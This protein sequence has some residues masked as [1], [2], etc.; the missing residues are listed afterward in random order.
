MTACPLHSPTEAHGVGQ[1]AAWLR[2]A[3]VVLGVC[4]AVN[5]PLLLGVSAPQF[6]ALDYF[7]PF[8]ILVADAAREGSLVLWSPLVNGGAPVGFEPQ[9]GAH[10]PLLLGIAWTFGGTAIGF[11]VYW[12][13]LW[14]LGGLGIL[15]L[16]RHLRAPP[17]AGVVGGVGYMFSAIYIG[18]ASH[19]SYLLTMSLFPWALWR[20]D[21]ALLRRS[22]GAAIQAGVAWGLSALGGYPGLIFAGGCFAA[23]W[24]C[25]RGICAAVERRSANGRGAPA[26]DLNSPL[27]GPTICWAAVVL[28]CFAA[29][30]LAVLSPTYAGFRAEGRGYTSRAEELPRSQ[31]LA[32]G[33]LHAA[34]LA[35]GTSPYL[36][37]ANRRAARPLWPTDVSMASIYLCPA[38]VV[39]A[40]GGCGGGRRLFR[41]ALA[42][43]AALCLALAM[44]GETP[45]YGFAYDW[46]PPLRFCRFPAMFRCFYLLAAVVLALETA[47]SLAESRAAEAESLRRGLAWT[48]LLLA[49]AACAVF[50]LAGWRLAAGHNT[51]ILAGVHAALGWLGVAAL[52]WLGAARGRSPG[53]R[54]FR[55]WLPALVVVDGVLTVLLSRGIVY[56]SPDA[57]RAM[58]REHVASVDLTARGLDRQAVADPVGGPLNQNL[59]AKAPVLESYSG[60]GNRFH[61]QSLRSPWAMRS[62]L[63]PQRV[64]FSPRA[65]EVPPTD[66]AFGRFAS[67]CGQLDAPCVVVFASE[68]VSAP[69]GDERLLDGDAPDELD[70]LPPARLAATRVLRYAPDELQ[71]E[72]V[73]PE[74]GWILVT[75]RWSRGWRAELNGEPA[76]IRAGNFIYRAL[77][78][79]AGENRIAFTYRPFG[80]PWLLVASWCILGATV[81]GTVAAQLYSRRR[82]AG[83]PSQARTAP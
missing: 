50:A 25:V 71:L 59:V 11:A 46:V 13:S 28:A 23:Y 51:L 27:M 48:A 43:I 29:S 82:P 21:A 14:C 38:L 58:L 39:L 55:K 60:L 18:H 57:C 31:V 74:D 52:T 16:A 7:C 37:I 66:E 41:G 12:A 49:I 8:F 53:G 3:A 61:D 78:V 34:N 4:L 36:A 75:D 32:E 67:R 9:V 15:L 54:V 64:W 1:N 69:A 79:P 26:G 2:A 10:S 73:A 81:A 40:V 65:A 62:A 33:N 30:G 63:G 45:L 20:L 80:H 6:D 35:T 77:R 83:E 24:T 5:A 68:E 76:P 42:L 19:T 72:V 70:A 44:G 22:W 17:W 56:S 47:R